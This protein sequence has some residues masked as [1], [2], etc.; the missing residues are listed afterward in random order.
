MSRRRFSTELE[1]AATQLLLKFLPV[2]RIAVRIIWED[3]DEGLLVIA[4]IVARD[5]AVG[6][7]APPR[8]ATLKRPELAPWCGVEDD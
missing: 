4:R 2:V 7:E 1:V 5:D 3:L 6:K 8:I